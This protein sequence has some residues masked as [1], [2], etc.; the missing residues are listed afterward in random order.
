MF[1]TRT[2]LEQC[3]ALE[4]RLYQAEIGNPRLRL[5]ARLKS[6]PRHLTWRY[7]HLL[8]LAGYYYTQRTRN[9]LRAAQYLWYCRRKNKLG[10]RLGIE[11]SEKT[12]APGLMLYHTVGTVVNGDARVG[13][14]CR[15]HGNNCIGNDGFSPR[16]P[17][18]G[19]N[20]R[21]GVGARVLGDVRLADGI[22]VAAGAVVVHSFEEPG[23]LL[24]GV[25]AR[26]I[27]MA[28]PQTEAWHGAED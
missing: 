12:F 18:L 28:R 19:D 22:L 8:R 27:G 4:R 7:V 23:I 24:G 1:T 13:R 21:L 9:P 14:N 20:V 6:H 5:L 11:L 2:E 15:L 17:V 25:P 10:R 16:C 3:L 26:K